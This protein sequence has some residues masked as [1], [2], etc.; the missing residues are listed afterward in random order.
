MRLAGKGIES[1]LWFWEGRG[2]RKPGNRWP[3]G[4]LLGPRADQ[5]F[6]V[7]LDLIKGINQGALSLTEQ[8]PPPPPPTAQSIPLRTGSLQFC[9]VPLTYSPWS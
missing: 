4:G 1:N 2:V 8:P 3:Q 9:N 6:P 7:E 5:I